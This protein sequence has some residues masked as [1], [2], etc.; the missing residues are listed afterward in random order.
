MI[1]RLPFALA[2]LLLAAGCGKSEGDT[3]P[4]PHEFALSLKVEAP[5]A[6]L[7]RIDLPP[8]A[9]IAIQRGDKG[10]IRIVDAHDRPLS[11][12]FVEPGA[13]KRNEV[14][15]D[16]IPFGEIGS[17][18]ASPVSIRVDQDGRSVRVQAESGEANHSGHSV[19][20]DTRKVREPAVGVSLKVSLPKQKPVTVSIAASTD[21]KT[22]EP[23]AEQVLFR[24]GGGAELLGGS[25]ISLAATNL[26]GRY[27]RASWS[28]TTQ[29]N[30][31]GATILTSSN[32]PLPR[33][34]IPIKGLQLA[35]AHDV[36]F[37]IPPG[38]RPTAMQVTM[39]GKDGVMPVR[40]FGR[41]NSESPWTLMA[42]ASLKQ[43][44]PG[45]ILDIGERP[46]RFLKL[47]ADRRSAGFSQVPKIVLQYA[48]ITLAVAFNGD[49][50]Y[51]LLV[52]NPEAK[53]ATFALSE[54]APKNAPLAAAQVVG[55]QAQVE[56]AVGDGADDSRVTLRVIALWAALLAGVV[57][58]GYA[59][60]KLMRANNVG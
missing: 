17:S 55:S 53:A 18:P 13:A 11:M 26:Y 5:G 31:T 42:L 20:F 1:R 33:V 34:S 48:P 54:L 37:A 8:A 2:L 28:D 24:A 56:L 50:P 14:Q 44:G 21:L 29:L 22:W 6:Q 47:E 41:D 59:A 40:L 46:T 4:Q 39:T 57:L 43:G 52:G 60:Y 45:A 10:D 3:G 7:L 30:I 36:S 49:G 32:P 51:R 23:L 25:Q 35:N 19:L 27:L 12:A 15:L 16:A 38:L 9:L 58:L